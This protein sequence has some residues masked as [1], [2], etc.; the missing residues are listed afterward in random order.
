MASNTINLLTA[1][2]KQI[3]AE[4]S[5]KKSSL[6]K[7]KAAIKLDAENLEKDSEAHMRAHVVFSRGVTIYQIAIAI[8]AIAIVT[9]RKFMWYISILLTVAGSYFLVMGFFTS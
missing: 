1:L 7:E 8:S 2:E 5:A 4:V 9:R 6:D 3:P